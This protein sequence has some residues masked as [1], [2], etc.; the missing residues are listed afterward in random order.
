MRRFAQSLM[1]YE[2]LMRGPPEAD[3]PVTF[4][5]VEKLHLHLARVMGGT[6][7]RALLSR[8]LALA[9]AEVS[10]LRA[11]HVKAD[12][13]LAGMD[14]LHAQLEPADIKECEVVLLARLLGLLAT[15]IGASLTLRM[16]TD[17]WPQVSPGDMNLGNGEADEKAP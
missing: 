2:I 16:M 1:A 14:A 12:G 9:G 15:F 3:A 7:Y 17:I 8:A 11:V 13:T 10:W 4:H 6:G 5:A